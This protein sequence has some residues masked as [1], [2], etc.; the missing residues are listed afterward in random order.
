M[1]DQIHSPTVTTI[2]IITA[3]HPH[4]VG[5]LSDIRMPSL[6][7]VSVYPLIP[8][9]GLFLSDKQLPRVGVG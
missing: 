6:P 3:K 7:T 8:L 9:P 2:A 1:F 5:F 4:G